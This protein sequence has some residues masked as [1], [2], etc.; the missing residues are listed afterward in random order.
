MLPPSVAITTTHKLP[1]KLRQQRQRQKAAAA[2]ARA[3]SDLDAYIDREVKRRTQAL[4]TETRLKIARLHLAYELHVN[5][6]IETYMDEF[7]ASSASQTPL[8]TK[9]KGKSNKVLQQLFAKHE[10]HEPLQLSELDHFR[11]YLKGNSAR[12]M[13]DLRDTDEALAKTSCAP[14]VDE[15]INTIELLRDLVVKQDEQLEQAQHLL[16]VAL[17]KVETSDDIV[18][19]LDNELGCMENRLDRASTQVLALRRSHVR[20]LTV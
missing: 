15:L 11:A 13:A 18:V 3:A 12:L 10:T 7:M 16:S 19:D 8:P 1:R 5:S 2:H 4:E 6:E 9:R 14:S 20:G 17:A